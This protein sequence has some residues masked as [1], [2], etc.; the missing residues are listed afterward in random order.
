MN[1]EETVDV[2]CHN[3]N[4]QTAARVI[5]SGYGGVRSNALN[6]IDQPDAEYHG[7]RYSVAI[8]RRCNDSFLIRTT[9]YGIPGEFETVADETVL[10][11][12][13]S[14]LPKDNIPGPVFR[15]YEQAARCFSAASYEASALMC[16]RALEA[17]CKYYSASG[18]SLQ[19]KLDYLSESGYIEKR[20]A[21]WAHEIRAVGNEAAHDT[22][23]ELKKEDARDALDFTEALFLYVFALNYRFNTFEGRRKDAR[24]SKAEKSQNK[25]P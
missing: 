18:K 1:E 12:N 19:A 24:E 17:L 21:Y 10:F 16:R 22:N 14:R 6:A 7:E 9:I 2:F 8:C 20:L 15:A 4:I 5:C 13:V 25:A 11:P 3:C 23:I